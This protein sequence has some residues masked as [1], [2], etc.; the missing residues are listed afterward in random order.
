MI[1]A[2]H[3]I[4]GAVA[5]RLVPANPLFAFFAGFVSHFIIDAI[6]H[7]DYQ[8]LSLK[9]DEGNFLNSSVVFNKKFLIDLT[10]FV[11]DVGSG[12]AFS[13]LVFNYPD[14]RA[15]LITVSGIAGAVLPDFLS[16]LYWV[17]K[18][19]PLTSLYRFHFWI[20]SKNEVLKSQLSKGVV[21]QLVF[22]LG[23]VL[24]ATYLT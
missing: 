13:L 4:V 21:F 1:L 16:F 24:I 22:V 17:I 5:A 19:E 7:W 14:Y 12:I 8:L 23:I 2:T 20:H 11:F 18:Q 3:A 6:P 9:K 15:Y 10:K